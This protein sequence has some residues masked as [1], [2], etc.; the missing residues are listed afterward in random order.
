MSFSTLNGVFEIAWMCI[1]SHFSLFPLQCR[2]AFSLFLLINQNMSFICIL[3]SSYAGKYLSFSL[4]PSCLLPG[5]YSF[6]FLPRVRSCVS[7]ISIRVGHG[8]ESSL[9]QKSCLLS[10]GL[11]RILMKSLKRNDWT[12]RL[13]IVIAFGPPL[14]YIKIIF[15][16]GLSFSVFFTLWLPFLPLLPCRAGLNCVQYFCV[17]FPVAEVC[18]FAERIYFLILNPCLGIASYHMERVLI[19]SQDINKFSKNIKSKK[20]REVPDLPN[21]LSGFNFIA[22]GKRKVSRKNKCMQLKWQL[23]KLYMWDRLCQKMF[24]PT[25]SPKLYLLISHPDCPAV[26]STTVEI[27]ALLLAGIVAFSV[28][29]SLACGFSFHAPLTNYSGSRKAHQIIPKCACMSYQ[30]FHWCPNLWELGSYIVLHA[31]VTV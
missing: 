18:M 1:V 8:S 27:S 5:M 19:T 23:S 15:Y 21:R 24:P 6:S 25:K 3:C 30:I 12:N 26:R 4:H 20:A 17:S 22:V 10:S 28:H 29:L 31:N 11:S 13:I 7:Y 14:N 2:T 16:F 9:I